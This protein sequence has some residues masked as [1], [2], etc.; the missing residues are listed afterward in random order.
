[1]S[2]DETTGLDEMRWNDRPSNAG[3]YETITVSAD[4]Y[5]LLCRRYE[6]ATELERLQRAESAL[7]AQWQ[8]EALNEAGT[9][10]DEHWGKFDAEQIAQF[11]RITAAALLAPTTENGEME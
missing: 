8:A 4:L 9:V 3:G 7:K 10:I 1:M 2:G 5:E 11:L 6:R